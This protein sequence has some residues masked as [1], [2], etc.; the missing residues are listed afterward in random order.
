MGGEYQ[1]VALLAHG[2]LQPHP[3]Q[4]EAQASGRL[5]DVHRN[6]TRPLES[7]DDTRSGIRDD[8]NRSRKITS[9]PHEQV[10]LT[11]SADSLL[12]SDQLPEAPLGQKIGEPRGHPV[13]R[14]RLLTWMLFEPAPQH[15]TVGSI[16]LVPIED[17]LRKGFSSMNRSDMLPV[18]E[19][20]I[21]RFDHDASLF[22]QSSSV[23]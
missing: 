11:L 22:C 12:A 17:E 6:I 5:R 4:G 7:L 23:K 20:G 13:G 16:P 14:S 1:A 15:R 8:L 9:D 21:D 18:K 10:D 19:N 3:R 2:E